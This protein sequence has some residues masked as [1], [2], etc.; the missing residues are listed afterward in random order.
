MLWSNDAH[1]ISVWEKHV[2]NDRSAKQ[3]KA[4]VAMGPNEVNQAGQGEMSPEDACDLF[5]QYL[6]PLKDQSGWKIIGAS[7]N[8]AANGLDWT[9]EFKSLCPDVYQK[10]DFDSVH[11]YG[12]DPAKAIAYFEKWHETFG[13]PLYITE[14]ACMNYDGSADPN[15]GQAYAFVKQV[16]DWAQKTSWVK[17][18]AFY[19]VMEKLNINSV[20]RLATSGGQPTNL[21]QYWVENTKTGPSTS[22]DSGS[23]DEDDDSSEEDDSVS[24]SNAGNDDDES[25]ENDSIISQVSGWILGNLPKPN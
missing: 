18:L 15:L 20:N 4:K 14:T 10:I 1:R 13:K 16:N 8:G 11:F 5:E 24:H 3:N 17:G 22:S 9:K 2:L 6:V 21:F 19:G 12:T 23:D 25:D 7:T